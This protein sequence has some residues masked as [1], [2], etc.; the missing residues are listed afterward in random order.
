M[1]QVAPKRAGA[2]PANTPRRAPTPSKAP[3]RRVLLCSLEALGHPEFRVGLRSWSR[4][5]PIR[6]NSSRSERAVSF[7]FAG[8]HGSLEANGTSELEGYRRDPAAEGAAGPARTIH[9]KEEH[10]AIPA[11]TVWPD[12]IKLRPPLRK[13]GRNLPTWRR[14]GAP[15]RPTKAPGRARRHRRRARPVG[16]TSDFAVADRRAAVETSS[17]FAGRP[18]RGVAPRPTTGGYVE[19]VSAH[20]RTVAPTSVTRFC[21]RILDFWRKAPHNNHS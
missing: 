19:R 8:C 9:P 11:P 14:K 18:P 5:D 2:E 6:G 1:P 3:A 10:V 7:R 17:A 16:L 15:S 13:P 20:T 21:A 12:C 4:I